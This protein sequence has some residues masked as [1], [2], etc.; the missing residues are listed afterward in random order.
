MPEGEYRLAG[1]P[2][3]LKDG[4]VRVKEHPEALAGSVLTMNAALRNAYEV[5]GYPLKDLIKTTSWNQAQALGLKK[6]DAFSPDTP[7]TS[8]FFP[9]TSRSKTSLW[10]ARCS[11]P[12]SKR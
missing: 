3:I 8:R 12:R 5:T 9:A 2:I 6:S 10:T 11:I 7:R 1:L 4:A